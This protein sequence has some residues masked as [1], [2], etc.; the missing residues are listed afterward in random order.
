MTE[1]F[2]RLDAITGELSGLRR[3]LENARTTALL[4]KRDPVAALL[5]GDDDALVAN[6]ERRITDLEAERERLFEEVF[7]GFVRRKAALEKEL[8]LARQRSLK[9]EWFQRLNSVDKYKRLHNM[10]AECRALEREL[11]SF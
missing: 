2:D 10:Q 9:L 1:L 7:E 4:K 8:T 6:M 3:Q 11:Q 5:A